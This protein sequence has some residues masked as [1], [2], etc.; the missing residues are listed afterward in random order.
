[1]FRNVI[2]SNA[3]VC[4]VSYT[5]SIHATP[6]ASTVTEKVSEMANKVYITAHLFVLVNKKVGQGLASVIETGEKA[7]GK[8]KKALGSTTASAEQKTEDAKQTTSKLTEQAKKKVNQSF[9]SASIKMQRSSRG[10]VKRPEDQSIIQWV[11]VNTSLG[12]S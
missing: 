7:A 12:K 5:R 6:A 2:T 8:T 3:R 11:N 1:M 4:T 9:A 10:P